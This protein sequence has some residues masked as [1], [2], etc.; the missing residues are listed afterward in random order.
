[1]KLGNFTFMQQGA[2]SH[3]STAVVSHNLVPDGEPFLGKQVRRYLKAAVRRHDSVA[4]THRTLASV[5]QEWTEVGFLKGH[6]SSIA[7]RAGM[8]TATLYRQF[9]DKSVLF[10]EALKFGHNI[11]LEGLSTYPNHPNPIRTLTEML[12]NQAKTLSQPAPQHFLLTQRLMLL[13]PDLKSPVQTIAT[14]AFETLKRNWFD[15]IQQLV[16]DGW[17]RIDRLAWQNSS[18][19]GALEAATADWFLMADALPAPTVNCVGAGQQVVAE[20]FR[21]FGTE[22]FHEHRVVHGWTGEHP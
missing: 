15:K 9:P 17:I 5:L 11:V 3:G 2:E 7:N 1:M 18:L 4:R 20:F 12:R 21:Q 13:D 8:S 10:C 19:L 22:K 6:M 14:A 16:G